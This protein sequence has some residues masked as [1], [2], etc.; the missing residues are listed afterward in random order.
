MQIHSIKSNTEA[1][2]HAAVLNMCA[3]CGVAAL[4]NRIITAKQF[5]VHNYVKG[6]DSMCVPYQFQFMKWIILCNVTDS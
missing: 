6:C 5:K 2:K 1:E 3:V 4:Y